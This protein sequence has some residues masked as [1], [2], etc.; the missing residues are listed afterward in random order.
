MQVAY[1]GLF[2][3]ISGI[4]HVGLPGILLQSITAGRI[5]DK[6]E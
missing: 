6:L 5:P 2:P 3:R 1:M 4:S